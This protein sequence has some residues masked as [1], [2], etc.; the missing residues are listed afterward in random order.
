MKNLPKLKVFL[1]GHCKIKNIEPLGEFTHLEVLRLGTTVK[2]LAPLNK[3]S[4]LYELEVTGVN[5]EDVSSINMMTLLTSINIH[6][7]A[8]ENMTLSSKLI[9]LEKFRL[10]DSKLKKLPDFSMLK[11][12]KEISVVR[13]DISSVDSV[14]DLNKLTKL[15]I[16]GSKNLATANGLNNLPNLKQ[17]KL[18]K[19][20]ITRFKTGLLPNLEKLDLSSTN[21]T[22]LEGFAS[23]PKLRKLN[24]L[25][26]KVISLAGAEDAPQ[27]RWLQTDR[28]FNYNIENSAILDRLDARPYIH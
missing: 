19:T 3:L 6:K 16:I 23:Y 14:H 15:H 7:N 22:K 13:S 8:I 4:K 21:V 12:I 17:L 2:S 18:N 25:D 10:I 9:H 1:C 5:L 26:S 24:L 27:L 11:N 28:D 20:S